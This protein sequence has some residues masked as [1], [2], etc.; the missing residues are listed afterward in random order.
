MEVGKA[1]Q[2]PTPPVTEE[3]YYFKLTFTDGVSAAGAAFRAESANL[4]HRRVGPIQRQVPGRS[5]ACAV[6]RCRVYGRTAV[7]RRLRPREKLS[8]AS[9]ETREKRRHAARPACHN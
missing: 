7:V 3:L 9:P 4:W 1:F 8:E 6:P 2:L 5:S